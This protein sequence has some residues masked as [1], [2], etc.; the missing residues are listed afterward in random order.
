MEIFTPIIQRGIDSG[1]FRALDAS[2]I[3]IAG[4]AI[5]EGTILLWVYDNDLVNPEYHIRRGMQLLL[6]GVLSRPSDM[7]TK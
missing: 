5:I 6:E 1:E 3:A 7:S 2:E 4:G